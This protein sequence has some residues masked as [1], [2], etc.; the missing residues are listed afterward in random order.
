MCIHNLNNHVTTLSIVTLAMDT[1]TAQLAAARIADD[2]PKVYIRPKIKS[3]RVDETPVCDGVLPDYLRRRV[4]NAIPT[5]IHY[6]VKD[7]GKGPKNFEDLAR[8]RPLLARKSQ[9]IGHWRSYLL[10]IVRTEKT[11]ANRTRKQYIA[12]IDHFVRQCI[13]LRQR[14]IVEHAIARF[15]GD[16]SARVESP[17]ARRWRLEG[18]EYL[19]TFKTE[20]KWRT[21]NYSEVCENLAVTVSAHRSLDQRRAAFRAW[22]SQVPEKPKN[23]AGGV[24]EFEDLLTAQVKVK[25]KTADGAKYELRMPYA[26]LHRRWHGIGKRPPTARVVQAFA[27]LGFPM[28]YLRNILEIHDHEKKMKPKIEAFIEKVFD[29]MK[30]KR[31]RAGE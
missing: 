3:K 10:A 2:S 18:F 19:A 1:I 24:P 23:V 9:P 25:V 31:S 30:K 27:Q 4:P 5:T 8:P 15:K 12:E 6:A 14:Q 7:Q 21:R 20:I 26:D 17:R 13:N 22:A 28:T 11:I 16:R 29:K